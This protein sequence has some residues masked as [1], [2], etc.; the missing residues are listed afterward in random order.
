MEWVCNECGLRTIWEPS[1]SNAA[2][3]CS[4]NTV[5]G[6]FTP[7]SHQNSQ[8]SQMMPAQ[9]GCNEIYTVPF[10]LMRSFAMDFM[11]WRC[12]QCEKAGLTVLYEWQ[13]PRH[14][15]Q[16]TAPQKGKRHGIYFVAT[17]FCRQHLRLLGILVRQRGERSNDP[18]LT[19]ELSRE[20]I[21]RLPH[22]PQCALIT[23]SFHYF[24]NWR[25]R[26]LLKRSTF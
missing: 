13:T 6:S 23:N 9:R 12:R 17:S 2:Q 7:L 25:L 4:W 1:N 5:I 18:I 19:A 10:S 26:M 3:L 14:E 21:R 22:C 15:V 20:A 16:C 11:A 24:I 8:K